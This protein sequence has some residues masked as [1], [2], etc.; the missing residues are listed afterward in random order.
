M[1][2]KKTHIVQN[3][4]GNVFFIIATK[5]V[6]DNCTKNSDCFGT[7]TTCLTTCKCI[8]ATYKVNSDKKDCTPPT[9][10]PLDAYCNTTLTC[11]GQ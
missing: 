11:T 2:P 9:P 5:L 1:L 4:F 10:Q 3:C 6:G 8:M 7:Y